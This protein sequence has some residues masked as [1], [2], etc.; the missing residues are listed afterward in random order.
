[1]KI[2]KGSLRETL[3]AMPGGETETDGQSGPLK[4]TRQRIY[5][6]NEV[7]YIS[8]K[9][10][11]H[12]ESAQLVLTLPRLDSIRSKMRIPM[13]Y[14]SLSTVSDLLTSCDEWL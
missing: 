2:L 13:N 12:V 10:R 4:V 6:E 11:R 1:M 9:V 8:D 3:Y 14:Q 7:T 5:S